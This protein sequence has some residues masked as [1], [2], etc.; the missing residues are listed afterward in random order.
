MNDSKQNLRPPRVKGLTISMAF[1]L[2]G[3][4]TFLV[5]ITQERSIYDTMGPNDDPFWNVAQFRTAADDFQASLFR[6]DGSN[7]DE[8]KKIRFQYEILLSKFFIISQKSDSTEFSYRQPEYAPTIA[9][10]KET[11]AK[12]DPLMEN[13][14]RG[15]PSTI[16][17]LH[18]NLATVTSSYE[19]FIKA[20][21]AAE[22]KRRDSVLKSAL[23]DRAI[24]LYSNIGVSLIFLLAIIMLDRSS[25]NFQ[26]AF[27]AAR[28][29]AHTKQVF[30]GALNH[31]L[32]NP[33]QT[34]VSAIDNVSDLPM[35]RNVMLAVFNIERAAKHIET[36]MR[37]LTDFLRLDTIKTNLNIEDVDL[38]Q[39]VDRTESRFSSA[40]IK[41]SLHISQTRTSQNCTFRSDEQRIQQIL[42]NIVENAVKYSDRGS[43]NIIFGIN[44][45][46]RE[47]PVQIEVMDEGAGIN[48]EKMKY[49]FSP[50]FQS[51]FPE[52]RYASGY[53]MGLAVVRGLIQVLGGTI[54]VDSQ[55][56][57]GTSFRMCFPA[58]FTLNAADR[59]PRASSKN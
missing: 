7:R 53:G 41:K 42:D 31:E 45:A 36:H 35:D 30:L 33:L 28:Q 50:F 29:V 22:I 49:L 21:G 32:R 43:I 26:R 56:E 3:W 15:G 18:Q 39:V 2:V 13:F 19:D 9:K 25:R 44:D 38:Q 46:N 1:L 10:L 34:I 11:F 47:L 16:D 57:K 24:L 12:M 20:I 52:H 6:F 48:E 5:S 4:L 40:A 58:N 54:E 14:P 23:R 37:D 59:S 17:I 55:V 27:E 51:H 8:A